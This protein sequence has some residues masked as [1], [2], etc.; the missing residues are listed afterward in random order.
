MKT[1][2]LTATALLLTC[3]ALAQELQWAELARRSDLWPAECTAKEK[4]QFDGGVTVQPGQKLKVRRVLPDEVEVSTLDE[5]TTFTAEPGETDV[6]AVARQAYAKL[7]PKQRAL[8]YEVL[9]RTKELWPQQVTLNRAFD[10]G[11]GRSLREG[12]PLILREVHADRVVLLSEKLNTTFQVALAATDF[13]A[14]AR[15]LVEDE[16]AAPRFVDAV[17]AAETKA[18]VVAEKKQSIGTVLTELEGK[19]QS[20]VTGQPSPL[21]PNALPRYIVFY[22]GSSTCPITRQFTPTLV[23]FYRQMHPKHPEFEVVYMMTENAADTSAFAR[24]QGFSWRAITYGSTSE[25][26]SVHRHISGLLP[27]LIVMDRNGRVLANGTQS[28]APMALRQ[29]D[30]LLKAPAGSR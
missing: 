7:T 12:E 29:L 19:M 15:K 22:R 25:I 23:N 5:R 13:M 16:K 1:L 21:D 11:G 10:I 27:Q 3:G 30:A 4:M 20:S 2:L 8:T 28:S 24:Q 9:T 18:Q 17:K 6:L 26:P 14:Q